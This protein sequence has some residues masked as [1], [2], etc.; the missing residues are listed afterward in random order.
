MTPQAIKVT[1]Q[2]AG[3]YEYNTW[4]QNALL[5]NIPGFNKN[6]LLC[7]TGFSGHGVQQ[8]PAAGLA[9]AELIA[10]GAY[11]TQPGLAVFDAGRVVDNIK[12]LERNIV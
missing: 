8:A 9:L 11:R 1:S 7:A 10:Y 12:V 2:W 4:D 5:G 3:F 6:S